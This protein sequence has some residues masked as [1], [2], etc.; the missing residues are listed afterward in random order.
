MIKFKV[1]LGDRKHLGKIY[2]CETAGVQNH[3]YY[4]DNYKVRIEYLII[5][6]GDVVNYDGEDEKHSLLSPHIIED[7]LRSGHW[8]ELE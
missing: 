4:E 1:K 2:F 5:K 8:V 6:T 3:I 7:H